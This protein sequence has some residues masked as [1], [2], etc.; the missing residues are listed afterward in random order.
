MN[1]KVDALVNAMFDIKEGV[2]L[3]VVKN[4]L[5][6]ALN[7]CRVRVWRE[8][9]NIPLPTYGK[10]GDACC[11][12]YAKEIVYD[13]EKDRYIVHT[14]LHFA[15]PEDYEMEL[16]PRSSNT[17]TEVYIPNSPCTLDSGY[18][19]E[20]LVVFKNRTDAQLFHCIDELGKAVGYLSPKNNTPE[21]LATM[22][23]RIHYEE[24]TSH[25][26]FPYKEGD[27]I[28]QL[29]VRKREQIIW[30]E[31]DSLESLG[32]TERGEGGFGSTGK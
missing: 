24:L 32:S 31:V 28:C 15:L 13:E 9:P 19:G 25:Q 4:N 20:L 17:K 10:D 8:D 26:Y 21:A 18:R 6:A 12:V 1:L 27:R 7:V 2:A 23:A 11:D 3:N 22:N 14:G 16:R 30:H 5:E 29:L